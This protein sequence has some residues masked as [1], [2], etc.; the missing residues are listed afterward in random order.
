MTTAIAG[1]AVTDLRRIQTQGGD[2]FHAMRA[3]DPGYA[4]FGEAYFTTILPAAEK[5][6]KRHNRMTLNLVVIFGHVRFGVFDDRPGSRSWG[7]SQIIDLGPGTHFARLTV[8]PGIWVAFRCVG[9]ES[10]LILN[11]A[12]MV[13]DDA[14]VDR[15]A[16]GEIPLDW[17]S[18]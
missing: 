2:V 3:S 5:P 14:E 4:G 1:L 18:S 6:W 11:V 15:K 13:H 8:A 12:D 7:K 16:L 9:E 17:S 10:G